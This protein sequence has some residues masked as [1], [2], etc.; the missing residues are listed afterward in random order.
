MILSSTSVRD[1]TPFFVG[2]KLL[3]TPHLY[4]VAANMAVQQSLVGHAE[5]NV[6]F[7]RPPFFAAALRPFTWM[8]YAHALLIWELLLIGSVVA[9]VCCLPLV[10]RQW[11]AIAA[12][13]SVPA[14][15]G[16]GCGN[17]A[18]VI[19]L[20][21]ALALLC[22]TNGRRFL[23][24]AVLGLC[25]AKFHLLLFLPL[26]LLQ[27]RYRRI[28]VGFSV[29][30]GTLLAVNWAVQP[31]WMRLYA[32]V[33]RMPPEN[34][35]R[36]N[37]YLNSHPVASVLF[38]TFLIGLLLWP[39]CQR[40]PFDLAL[41]ICILGGV[42]ASPHAGIMDLVLAIPALLITA[43]RFPQLKF[44]AWLLLSP[45]ATCLYWGAFGKP[46]AILFIAATLWLISRVRQFTA[47]TSCS[48]TS[49]SGSLASG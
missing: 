49:L 6:S 10:P 32:H 19:V 36:A 28:L 38:G 21:I 45:L 8:A 48:D 15:F 35:P 47:R 5:A 37:F 9:F 43:H 27:R 44:F 42:M 3:G 1:F 7:I 29:V 41:P 34:I 18:T 4:D 25:L 40:A 33:L 23:A 14:M 24:G 30:T 11:T 31:G 2:A 16:I 17:D 39:I 26:L 13:C 12:W 22:W 20:W 46:G